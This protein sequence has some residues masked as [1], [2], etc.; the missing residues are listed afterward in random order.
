MILRNDA[1]LCGEELTSL[2]E[3]D[4]LDAQRLKGVGRS[5][6][7]A[8]APCVQFIGRYRRKLMGPLEVPYEYAY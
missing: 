2:D 8:A 5:P 3:A 6:L 7:Y 4:R 1:K